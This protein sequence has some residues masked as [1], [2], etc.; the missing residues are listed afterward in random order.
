[1]FKI[2]ILNVDLAVG[3]STGCFK[4]A[5]W[6]G[7]PISGIYLKEMKLLSWRDTCTSMFIAALYIVVKTWKQVSVDE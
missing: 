6:S 7:N 3:L 4:A 5:E 1:M 2:F